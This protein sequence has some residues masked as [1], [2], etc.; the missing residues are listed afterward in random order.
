M[1]KDAVI[2]AE[3]RKCRQG[4]RQK[5]IPTQFINGVVLARLRCP[6]PKV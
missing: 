2:P 5:P 1:M 6:P 3:I 4:G